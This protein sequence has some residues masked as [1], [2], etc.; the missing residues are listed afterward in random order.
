MVKNI[1]N[2]AENLGVEDT[3]KYLIPQLTNL[4]I[5]NELSELKELAII[6]GDFECYV[7][8]PKYAHILM[9]IRINN[10]SK[11]SSR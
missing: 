2:V 1:Q 11:L 4:I 3:R 6:L 5:A 9:V 7:G 10:L 8:G